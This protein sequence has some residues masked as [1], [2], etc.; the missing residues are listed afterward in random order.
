MRNYREFLILSYNI[1]VLR[2]RLSKKEMAKRLG[3]G[4]LTKI[5]KGILPPRL[6]V[7]VL[8]DI[9]VKDLLRPII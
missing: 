8:F 7:D 9:E 2:E 6:M 3:I 5:E 1:R 4:T